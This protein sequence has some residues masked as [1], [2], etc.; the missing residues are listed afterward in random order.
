MIVASGFVEVN[1]LDN[2]EKIM[3][4]LKSRSI[5]VSEV[6]DEK[7]VFL[8]E[9]KDMEVVKAE[10]DSLKD[11]DNVKNVHLAYYS[12]EGSDEGPDFKDRGAGNA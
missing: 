8:I 4:E 2:V 1:G 3:N 6:K 9:R 10:L 7:V 12:L 11:I 5:E